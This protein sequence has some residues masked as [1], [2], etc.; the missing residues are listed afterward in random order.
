MARPACSSSRN[1][2]CSVAQRPSA[3]P[4]ALSI[5]ESAVAMRS[6]CA[7]GCRAS[8]S[9]RPGREGEQLRQRHDTHERH[10]PLPRRPATGKTSTQ[11]SPSEWRREGS[12]VNGFASFAG[13][14]GDILS[15]ALG[16][17]GRTGSDYRSALSAFHPYPYVRLALAAA[18]M[19]V[20]CVSALH[21]V[22]GQM[23]VY[24][25]LLRGPRSSS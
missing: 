2:G 6:N 17:F 13:F 20:V 5:T 10:P 25:D 22:T 12:Q 19:L 9:S 3:H 1:R 16:Y 14:N 24:V 23:T 21:F 15:V 7:L 18:A 4:I 8:P 11:D